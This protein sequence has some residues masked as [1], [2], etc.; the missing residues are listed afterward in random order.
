[1]SKPVWRVPWT[2]VRHGTE[3]EEDDDWYNMDWAYTALN[4]WT[5]LWPGAITDT[6]ADPDERYAQ[7]EAIMDDVLIAFDML[8]WKVVAKDDPQR[9]FPIMGR[10]DE[11]V[12]DWCDAS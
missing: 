3:Y 4:G 8:G 10:R 7:G 6:S 2:E 9:G 1:M 11:F 12:P 5:D